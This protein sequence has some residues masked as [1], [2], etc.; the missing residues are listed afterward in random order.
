MKKL[1]WLEAPWRALLARV[2]DFA[3]M[4]GLAGCPTPTDSATETSAAQ[5]AADQF[6]ADQSAVLAKTVDAVGPE[7]EAAVN[8]ALAALAG[9]SA[10]AQAL[11]GRGKSAAGQ[12]QGE[13]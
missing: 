13:A 3:L 4:P 11:A 9:L 10:E 1:L 6:R 2:L 8:A 7:D 5:K 12:P